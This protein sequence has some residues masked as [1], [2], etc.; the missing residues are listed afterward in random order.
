MS[1]FFFSFLLVYGGFQQSFER[2]KFIELNKS[3]KLIETPDITEVPVLE[4]LILEDCVKLCEIH[5]SAG[6]HERL[7]LLNLKGCKSLKIL[8]NRFEMKSLDILILSGCLKLKRIPEFAKNMGRVSRLYLDGIA[9]TKL[10]TSIG[11]LTSLASLSVRDCKNLMSLPLTLFN[12]KS[13]VNINFSGCSKLCKLLENLGTIESVEELDVGGSAIRMMRS[14]N[15]FFKTLKK[16]AFG[17]FNLRSPDPMGSLSTSPLGLCSLID[18]DI[19]YCNL[20]AI[21]NDICCLFSLKHLDLSGNNFGCLPESIAQLSILKSLSIK[22]CT[23]LLSLPK[24]PLNIDCIWGFDC[25][26][27]ETIPNLLKPNSL[28][29]AELW[30]SGCSKLVDNQGFIDMFLAVIK[31]IIQVSLSLSLSFSLSLSLSLCACAHAF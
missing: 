1:L 8:P 14:S 30:L 24:L 5:P 15:A 3:L 19:S 22:N 26:S 25:T 7:T 9:I 12:M 23:S 31:K 10:P 6:V 21:P 11:N 28:C 16:L 4:K 13:L 29:E 20:N 17:G 2:L 27:L 18:L